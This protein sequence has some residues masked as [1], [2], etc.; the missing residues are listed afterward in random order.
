MIAVQRQTGVLSR[1]APDEEVANRIAILI[2]R[3]PSARWPS[4]ARQSIEDVII[5][6]VCYPAVRIG[7]GFHKPA[8]QIVVNRRLQSCRRSSLPR[9]VRTGV[10]SVV[11]NPY[12][13]D[14]LVRRLFD[15]EGQTLHCAI[16]YL[17]IA[18]CKV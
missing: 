7:N 8:R 10:F 9:R 6:S 1:Q 11:G 4:D 5:R 13:L 14:E 15:E 3:L 12:V 18:I 17:P 16:S 2:G